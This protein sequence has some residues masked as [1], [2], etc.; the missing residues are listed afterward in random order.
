MAKNL[1]LNTFTSLVALVSC[2]ITRDELGTRNHSNEPSSLTLVPNVSPSANT[3]AP[4]LQELDFL[5]SP[6]Y[7]EFFTV[8]NSS[9][10]KSSSPSNNSQQQDT[11]PTTNAH[12]TTTPINLTAVTAEENNIDIQ[13]KIQSDDAQIDENEF[14]NI[15]STPVREE[16]ES[17]TRYVDSSNKHTFYQRH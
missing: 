16:A 13:A 1:L 4:L 11:H 3:T 15:F 9:V 5:F 10:P 12:S 2:Y 7:N 17:S 14:Y 6:L 8:G